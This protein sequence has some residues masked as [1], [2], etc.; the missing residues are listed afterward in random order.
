[1]FKQ[2]TVQQ[3]KAWIS[4]QTE[5]SEEIL[6]QLQADERVG[7]QRLLRAYQRQQL[8]KQQEQ[9]RLE[10]MWKYEKI[11][12]EQGFQAIAGIDEAGRG[13]LAGP[14][15]AAAVIL[16]PD[17]DATGLDDSKRLSSRER[18]ELRE[19]IEKEAVAVGIGMVD[20]AYIDQHNILQATYQAMRI[21]IQ[22]LPV[23][24][25]YLLVDAVKIPGISLPQQGIIK[26]DQLSHSIAAA[27]IVAKTVR[28]QW[29]IDAANT[30]PQYGFDKHMGYGTPEHLAAL[31]KWGASPIHRQSFAPV[32]DLMK[33]E[34]SANE[35]G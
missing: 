20:V 18:E 22:S 19:R 14:V 21:A 12:W 9:E 6:G 4:E 3:I 15:V 26:G 32:R 5:L 29:M 17:F 11:G 25:D 31:A 35:V 30:Y 7:V 33:Q 24:A 2:M 27:S 28:D 10:K 16:P 13:P 1:M 34:P 23:P 8:R